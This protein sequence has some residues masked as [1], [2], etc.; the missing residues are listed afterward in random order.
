MIQAE[1]KSSAQFQERKAQALAGFANSHA[2]EHSVVIASVPGPQ[3]GREVRLS[4]APLDLAAELLT[5]GTHVVATTA[6]CKQFAADREA[7]ARA[8]R[9]QQLKEKQKLALSLEMT[10]EQAAKIRGNG[11]TATELA[12]AMETSVAGAV[13][14]AIRAVLSAKAEEPEKKAGK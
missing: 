4:E 14:A 11:V 13:E 8:F 12:A 9:E 3:L 10:D 6:Q 1:N 5:F 7:S 2:G